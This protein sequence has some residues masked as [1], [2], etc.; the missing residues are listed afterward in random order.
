MTQRKGDTMELS[1]EAGKYPVYLD[2][3]NG[4]D[5]ETSES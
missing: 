5:G 3:V 2:W 1:S 4:S